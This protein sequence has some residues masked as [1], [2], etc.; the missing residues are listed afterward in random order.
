M[1]LWRITFHSYTYVINLKKSKC[2]HAIDIC[3]QNAYAISLLNLS[4]EHFY[5]SIRH[6][7]FNAIPIQSEQGP[8]LQN[9]FE[10]NVLAAPALAY[11]EFKLRPGLLQPHCIRA[12]GGAF[13]ADYA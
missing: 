7:A 5:V 3:I 11:I 10:Q 2:I 8:N 12:L 13:A 1:S 9:G 6:R 4:S